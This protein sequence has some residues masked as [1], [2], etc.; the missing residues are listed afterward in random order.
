MRVYELAKELGFN[1]KEFIERLKLFNVSVNN[2]LSAIDEDTAHLIRLEIS[3]LK[4][5][6]LKSNVLNLNFPITVKNLAVKLGQK[7]SFVLQFFLNNLKP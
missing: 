4:D 3:D 2:H 7:S 5:K 1:S 6:E